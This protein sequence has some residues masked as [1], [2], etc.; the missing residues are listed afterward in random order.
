MKVT[1]DQGS[2][3]RLI[4]RIE[5]LS[6]KVNGYKFQWRIDLLNEYKVKVAAMMGSVSGRGG[7]P[8][9]EIQGI[10]ETKHWNALQPATLFR[11]LG[12]PYDPADMKGLYDNYATETTIWEDTGTTKR[13]FTVTNSFAG[14]FSSYARK[15]E[16]GDPANI[17]MGSPAPLVPRPLFSLANHVVRLTIQR[18]CSNPNHPLGKKMRREFVEFA[19][20]NGVGT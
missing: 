19:R 13:S 2:I 12:R 17:Y 4:S 6:G 7:Y 10:T 18:A 11:K 9:I 15:V 14:V 8:N 20:K 1:V 3:S 5:G 16:E